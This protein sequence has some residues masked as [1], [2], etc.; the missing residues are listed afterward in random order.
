[1]TGKAAVEAGE[2]MVVVVSVE[3]RKTGEGTMTTTLE[4]VAVVDAEGEMGDLDWGL[5]MEAG[6]IQGT[7]ES[8]IGKL[9][10][11]ELAE[12]G[13]E[14]NGKARRRAKVAKEEEE[15]TLAA[16]RL[17]ALMATVRLLER[18]VMEVVVLVGGMWWTER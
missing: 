12:V 18:P 8:Q 10:E 1:M 11:M 17:G 5:I 3:T 6:V 9:A 15:S 7:F 16:D 2:E 14:G 13:L 4:V